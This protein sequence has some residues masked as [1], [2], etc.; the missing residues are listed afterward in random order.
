MNLRR[1]LAAAFLAAIVAAPALAQTSP[2]PS[3]YKRLGGYD[4]IA[5]V[6]DDFLGRLS[7]NPQ[8]TKFFVG[9]ST[10]SLKKLRQNVVEF[11]CAGTG[12]PCV[13]VGR[14]MKTSH[15]GL[16]ITA[17]DWDVMLKDL[18]ATLDKFNVPA[19]EREDVLGAVAG[20]RKDIVEKP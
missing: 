6:S 13:Y 7:T 15:A 11:L 1:T 8:F 14:D 19:K 4:A 18:N 5:A 17:Q 9:H 3:L 10:D 20:L 2:P 12:G 16:N